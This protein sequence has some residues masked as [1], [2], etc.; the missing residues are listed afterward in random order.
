MKMCRSDLE[1]YGDIFKEVDTNNDGSV[2]INELK[3]GLLTAF[4]D[5]VNLQ[6]DAWETIFNNID[7]NGDGMVDYEEWIVAC[8]NKSKLITKENIKEIFDLID[9]D[10]SGDL[11]VEELVAFLS[12]RTEGMTKE[13][14]ES[15]ARTIGKLDRNSKGTIDYQEFE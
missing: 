5:R 6:E 8:T 12:S 4:G 2:N 3:N 11:S 9:T 1:Y 7:L 13:R 14:A 15:I 10:G